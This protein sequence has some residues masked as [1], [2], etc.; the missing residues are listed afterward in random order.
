MLSQGFHVQH[1][2]FPSELFNHTQQG[3]GLGLTSRSAYIFL[4]N[5]ASVSR[6]GVVNQGC[7]FHH[8]PPASAVGLLTVRLNKGA[9]ANLDVICQHFSKISMQFCNNYSPPPDNRAINVCFDVS[10]PEW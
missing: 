1:R 10:I 5:V 4:G 3:P 9:R 2:S 7:G 6:L 8:K